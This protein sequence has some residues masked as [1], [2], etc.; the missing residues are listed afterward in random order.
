MTSLGEHELE[1]IYKTVLRAEQAI[2]EETRGLKDVFSENP[3]LIISP[4]NICKC[5][6]LHCVAESSPAGITMPYDKFV[7]INPEFFRIFSAADFGRRGNPLLYNSDGH[8]LADLLEFLNAQGLNKFTL[9]LTL[10]KNPVPVIGRLEKFA[11]QADIETMVTYHH[12]FNGLDTAKLARDFNSTL[13]HYMRFSEK[14]IISL[15]GDKYSQKEPTKAEEV[16]QTFNKN[17]GIIFDGIEMVSRDGAGRYLAKHESEQVQIYIP[18]TDT[19]VY[20]FGRFRKYLEQKGILQ[21][22][23]EQF[24]NSMSDY[25]CPDLI[26][27]PGIIV[28]PDGGLNLCASFEAI[29][30][31]DSVVSN[32]FAKPYDEVKNELMQF[33]QKELR[34]F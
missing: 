13:K 15:L 32:I 10:Q 9:A 27:W 16:E 26:K 24:T 11:E 2:K 30:S 14:I 12:Y 20:P 34:W 19:R 3:R 22:Y 5:S 23:E 25:S 4:N 21:Q 18:K 33:H 17:W 28:E 6:C 31:Q 29:C 8:D 7:S 1:T